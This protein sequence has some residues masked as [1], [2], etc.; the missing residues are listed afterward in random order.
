MLDTHAF[1]GVLAR[2]LYE[3]DVQIHLSILR[4]ILH[5]KGALVY[6]DGFDTGNLSCSL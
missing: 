5:V 6:L 4:K 3:Y 2:A 1:I